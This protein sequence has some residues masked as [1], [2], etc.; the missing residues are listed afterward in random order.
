[1]PRSSHRP[2]LAVLM[3]LMNSTNIYALCN[4]G[5]PGRLYIT[6]VWPGTKSGND[7]SVA[8][9]LSCVRFLRCNNTL[10]ACAGLLSTEPI[11]AE[12]FK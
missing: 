12:V 3:V 2:Y 5:H 8:D 6:Y 7:H 11:R 1:M 9:V 4:F 10:S